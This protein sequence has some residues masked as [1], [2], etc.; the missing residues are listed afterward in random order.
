M[1][2]YLQVR[3]QSKMPG[4]GDFRGLTS[5][6]PAEIVKLKTHCFKDHVE[7]GSHFLYKGEDVNNYAQVTLNHREIAYRMKR[8]QLSLFLKKSEDP[9]FD[10]ANWDESLVTSHL[11]GKK[12]C[13]K[14]EHLELETQEL[15]MARSHCF[16][17]G[18]CLH[19]V[20]APDCI[21]F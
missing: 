15:N 21:I 10:M 14:W 17:I 20:N 18:R 19:H 2:H 5:P 12:R 8:H 3:I 16:Q 4:F 9:A 7:V 11:C 6:T 1:P 13:V